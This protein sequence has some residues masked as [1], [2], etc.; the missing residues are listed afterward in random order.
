MDIECMK[1]Y[2][3]NKDFD[4]ADYFEMPDY[5]KVLANIPQA[6]RAGGLIAITG[7]VGIG[8]TVALRRLQQTLREDKQIIVSKSFATDKRRV[9]ISTLY[10]ALFADLATKKD[11]RLPT[12]AEK[13]ERKLQAM[14]KEINKPVALFIDEA[15]DLHPRTLIG[16]KHLIET[17]QDVNGT[18]AMVLIGHPKLTNDLHNP[19]LEEVG[20]RTKFFEFGNLGVN[21]ASL[22][23]W[24]LDNCSKEK[25]KPNE[26]LAKDAIKLLSERLITPLQIIYYL[27]S[28]IEKG[29]QIGEKPIGCETLN[30]ILSPDL[31]A[32]EPSLARHGYNFAVLCERLNVKRHEIKAYLR[33]QLNPNRAEEINK[34]IYK[35]GVLV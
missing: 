34:E 22:V 17:I 1:Y 10:T 7:I 16:L 9:S 13:R 33:G 11:G 6:I 26:I 25:V 4:K 8:K 14:V 19:A 24:L 12:Q 28:A 32:I 5:Q 30:S 15:H 18:L 27:A 3:I 2:G 21:S 31:D 29:Y 35:L 23:E 20:A